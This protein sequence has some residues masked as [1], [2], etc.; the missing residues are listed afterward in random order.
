MSDI[1]DLLEFGTIDVYYIVLLKGDVEYYL[2]D[3]SDDT[4]H[5]VWTTRSENALSFYTD[6]EAQKH[7]SA[8]EKT[9][10]H[11]SLSLI[12]KT[13]NVIDELLIK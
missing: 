1:D 4:R 7:L 10:H 2:V 11:V 5:V 3:M 6:G 13:I 9:R 12:S 8:I